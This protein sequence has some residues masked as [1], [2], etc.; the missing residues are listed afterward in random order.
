MHP[1]PVATL[2]LRRIAMHPALR[3]F[4][5]ARGDLAVTPRPVIWPAW[6]RAHHVAQRPAPGVVATIA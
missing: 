4:F 3:V 2:V 1:S 6:V 5:L